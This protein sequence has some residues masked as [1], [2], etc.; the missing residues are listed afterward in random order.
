MKLG[1]LLC[2]H[3]QPALQEEFAD[4][5]EMFAQLLSQCDSTIEL[6]YYCV[7]DGVFPEDIDVCDAYMTSGSKASV[8]DDL[9]WI[10]AL[11]RFVWQLFLAKKS[12]VGI[13]FGHQ[14]IAKTLGG[15]VARSDKGWGVGVATTK[16]H[17]QEAWMDPAKKTIK[18]VVSHQEQIYQ[19]PPQAEVLM[20][21]DFCPY[22]MIQV[23]KHFVGLQGHPE[24]SCDYAKAIMQS[25]KAIISEENYNQGLKSLVQS[26]DGKL[27]MAWLLSFLK[28]AI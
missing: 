14:L 26:A 13:C 5:Q 21:N 11:E 7:V 22:A 17:S 1:I 4:Y 9:P 8:N 19:L 6:Y 2:D 27:V 24:F 20:G 16:I 23:G 25:R 3:V 15:K 18:L 12:F 10:N 28:Q